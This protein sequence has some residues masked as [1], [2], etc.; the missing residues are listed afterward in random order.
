VTRTGFVGL[1]LLGTIVAGVVVGLLLVAQSGGPQV[2]D[3]IVAPPTAASQ[4][5]STSNPAPVEGGAEAAAQAIADAITEGDSLKF[6]LITCDQQSSAKLGELQHK[7]DTAGP[8][9][10]T[11]P[12]PPVVNGDSASV[13]IHVTG[14]GGGQKDTDFPLRKKGG[15][16]CLPG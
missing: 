15:G 12:R 3:K 6:G 7:W 14:S 5:R 10:A 8:V 16:W 1:I 2:Y 4:P 9:T 11:V 13:T